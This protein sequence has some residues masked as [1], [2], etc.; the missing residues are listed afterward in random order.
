VPWELLWDFIG[1]FNKAEEERKNKRNPRI[2]HTIEVVLLKAIHQGFSIESVIVR[3]PL[4][5]ILLPL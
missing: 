4:G 5:F 1:A 3:D 2:R